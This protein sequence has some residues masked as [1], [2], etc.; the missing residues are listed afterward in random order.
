MCAILGPFLAHSQPV[1]APLSCHRLQLL[2]LSL[3]TDMAPQRSASGRIVGRS[4]LSPRLAFIWGRSWRRITAIILVRKDPGR[5]NEVVAT[6]VFALLARNKNNSPTRNNLLPLF[7]LTRAHAPSARLA[8][9]HWER[10]GI[11]RRTRVISW[12][13]KPRCCFFCSVSL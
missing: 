11:P 7:F 13:P 4:R 2:G 3:S 5:H 12:I 10:A 6:G 9:S 1:I 8:A